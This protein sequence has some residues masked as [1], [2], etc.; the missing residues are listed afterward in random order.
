MKKIGFIIIA[1][2]LSP[3]T[4]AQLQE[5]SFD[6]SEIPEG[7]F[8]E[9]NSEAAAWQFGYTGVMPHSGPTI[10]SE[11]VSGAALFNDTNFGKRTD[12]KTS[13]TTPPVDL[14]NVSEAQIEVTYNLQVEE[15]KGEFS[16]EVFDGRKWKEVFFQD[17]S[18]PKNTGMNEVVLVEVSEFVNEDFQVR[19]VYDDE[20]HENTQGLGI[21]HYELIDSTKENLVSEDAIGAINVLNLPETIL[22]LESNELLDREN[23]LK[24]LSE[25]LEETE[26][27]TDSI[28]YSLSEFEDVKGI[29]RVQEE[30]NVGSYKALKK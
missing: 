22:V 2:L 7:W 12:D 13:L 21:D 17:T 3:F 1:L 11:F 14:S 28:M 18:S 15:E 24:D 30:T 4:F 20:G 5:E 27:T 8:Y 19:F 25:H 29:F 9:I 23:M 10:E 6:G 26:L 16:I